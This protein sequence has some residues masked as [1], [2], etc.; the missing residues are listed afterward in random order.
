MQ[1]YLLNQASQSIGG[2]ENR[3]RV[4]EQSAHACGNKDERVRSEKAANLCS[5]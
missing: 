2:G 5:E 4:I 1:Y 3:V